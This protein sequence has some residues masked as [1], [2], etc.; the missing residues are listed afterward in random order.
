MK[1]SQVGDTEPEVCIEMRSRSKEEQLCPEV[2]QSRI[3]LEFD[4]SRKFKREW[5]AWIAQYT[6]PLDKILQLPEIDRPA[7][8]RSALYVQA[9]A[10]QLGL[11]ARRP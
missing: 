3:C 6:P 7:C 4:A 9:R 8:M 1:A 2:F 11:P 10:A 5:L